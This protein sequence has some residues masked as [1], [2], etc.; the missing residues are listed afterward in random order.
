MADAERPFD[1]YGDD[2][3]L[4]EDREDDSE[5]PAALTVTE[6]LARAHELL[7]PSQRPT[8]GDTEEEPDAE[9]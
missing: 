9:R 4:L 5:E 8:D 2:E 7:G 3:D 1:M 6:H